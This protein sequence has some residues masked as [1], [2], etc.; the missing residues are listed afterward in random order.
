M[1]DDEP[2]V[3]DEDAPPDNDIFQ[4]DSQGRFTADPPEDNNVLVFRNPMGQ[5]TVVPSA[6]ATEGERAYRCYLNRVGGMSWSQ[7][8]EAEGY[9][10]AA[11][12]H[13]DVAR[14]MT[15]AKALIAE[16]SMRDMLTLEVARL[17]AMQASFWG[18]ALKGHVPSGRMVLDVIKI[19]AAMV[20]LDP[21]KMGEA[22]QAARTVV[23]STDTESG[24]IEDLK[25]QSDDLPSTE[26]PQ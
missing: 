6:V 11:A 9:P 20:G 1:S 13:A 4:R 8:A 16:S 14:Y 19:R 10:N 24:F 2:P 17:D 22:A 26:P 18:Q 3:D 7:I 23:I 12:A 21:E 5:P 25:R 15:E